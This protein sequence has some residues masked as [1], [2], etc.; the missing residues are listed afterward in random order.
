MAL[1]T[2]PF[3]PAFLSVLR[4]VCNGLAVTSEEANNPFLLFCHKAPTLF[5]ITIAAS[6]TTTPNTT[7]IEAPLLRASLLTP[8][9]R[10]CS[11]E[12]EEGEQVGDTVVNSGVAEGVSEGRK[13]LLPRVVAEGE[14]E[15]VSDG[16]PVGEL[17]RERHETH[18]SETLSALKRT[19]APV[20][21]LVY[22]FPVTV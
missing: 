11:V 3:L 2:L 12:F 22:K 21:S 18:E 15:G 8:V 13:A 6:P 19:L 16:E 4:R 17:L 14:T 20:N 7:P 9:G 10:L 5:A 1:S